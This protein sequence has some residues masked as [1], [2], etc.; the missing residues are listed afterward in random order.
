MSPLLFSKL[1][2]TRDRRRQFLAALRDLSFEFV[3]LKGDENEKMSEK[4]RVASS[5]MSSE[6]SLG[7]QYGL[8]LFVPHRY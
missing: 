4:G 8:L 3:K 5:R 7:I 1:L 6:L 2:D